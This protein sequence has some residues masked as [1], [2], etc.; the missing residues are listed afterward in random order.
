MEMENGDYRAINRQQFRVPIQE[1]L[2]VYSSVEW[3]ATAAEV[4]VIGMLCDRHLYDWLAT[5]HILL[6]TPTEARMWFDQVA[7]QF[8]DEVSS[9]LLS[10]DV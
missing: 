4:K 9:R 5:Q 3:G 10:E 8:N 1:F 6:S 7:H 2:Q